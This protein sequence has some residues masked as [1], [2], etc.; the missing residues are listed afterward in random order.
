MCAGFAQKL[1]FENNRSCL[2]S[3]LTRI[4]K[5]MFNYWIILIIFSVLGMFFDGSGGIPG[6]LESFLKSIVLLH[7]YNGAWWYLNT[8]VI[9]LLIPPAILFFPVR[10]LK[11]IPGVILCGSLHILLYVAGKLGWFPVEGNLGPFIDFIQKE[12]DNLLNILPF[13]WLGGFFCKYQVMEKVA[14]LFEKYVSGK[15][16]NPVLL[17]TAIITF[18]AANVIHKAIIMGVVAV[19]VFMLFNLWKKG[20]VTQ[21]IMLFLG[22]HSMNIWL[23]HMF[24]YAYFLKD[25]VLTLKYPVPMF[26]ALMF[27]SLLSS[28]IV[29]LV[30]KSLSF[31]INKLKGS[32]DE[33]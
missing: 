11:L 33:S 1:L 18:V 17:F 2:R 13:V 8:Y 14:A 9:M 29:I 23:V 7:S 16:R 21:K 30:K 4:L 10:K 20:A 32:K 5:L 19:I 15:L 24:F 12:I 25:L 28:Y 3:R 27:W 6:S 22:Q 26:L 31:G